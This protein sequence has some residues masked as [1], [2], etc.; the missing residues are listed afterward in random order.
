MEDARDMVINIAK[1]KNVDLI[2]HPQITGNVMDKRP[3]PKEYYYEM[4]QVVKKNDKAVE[5]TSIQMLELYVKF[6]TK[7]KDWNWWSQKLV[8]D[9]SNYIQA[10]VESRVKFVIGTDAHNERLAFGESGGIPWPRADSS[11]PWFGA[12][13]KTVDYLRKY[14]A[15]ENNLWIPHLKH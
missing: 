7:G 5:C 11:H 9:Y 2:L 1:N 13:E 4:M 3:V 6:L 15:N 12:T 10:V 8:E 14:N